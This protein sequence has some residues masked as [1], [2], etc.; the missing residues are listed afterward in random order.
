MFF[1]ESIYEQAII[2][3]FEGMGYTHIYAPDMNREDFSSPLLLG[4][5]QD[6]LVRINRG[7]P[8]AAIREAMGKL[9]DFEGGSLVQKNRVFTGYLQDGV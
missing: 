2:Q 6:A 5:L 8:M 7:L 9:C 3:L 4:T 1:T